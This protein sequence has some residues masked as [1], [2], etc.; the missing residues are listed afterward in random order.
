MRAEIREI[1]E[2][3]PGGSRSGRCGRCRKDEKELTWE[4]DNSMYPPT[5]YSQATSCEYHNNES[6]ETNAVDGKPKSRK[7][8]T[9]VF[10]QDKRRRYYKTRIFFFL[11]KLVFFFFLF[12]F[13][14]GIVSICAI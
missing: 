6:S 4:M 2:G 8:H 14:N 12:A 7:N 3:A 1:K 11:S 9:E 10:S 5:R 13:G